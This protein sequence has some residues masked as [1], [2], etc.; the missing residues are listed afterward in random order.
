MASAEDS[1]TRS[2]DKLR[3][4]DAERK[5]QLIVAIAGRIIAHVDE[6]TALD[7]AIGDGDHGHNMR[8]GFEAVLQDLDALEAMGLSDLLKAVGTKLVMKVGGASGPLYGTL[9]LALGK[10]LP[11]EPSREEA[12]AAFVAAIAA[13]RARG[14]SEAGPEDHARRPH[15]NLSGVFRG[16][17]SC[18]RQEGGGGRGRSDDADARDPRSRFVPRRAI[19][20]S[21]RS[22]RA[23]VFADDRGA[24]R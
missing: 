16:R 11:D 7:A 2:R 15:S 6:L 3:A 21:H 10:A 18:R 12:A 13:V 1:M 20:R 8:R 14:K 23:V 17:R 4:L 9:F 5:R 24:L 19:D 22:R